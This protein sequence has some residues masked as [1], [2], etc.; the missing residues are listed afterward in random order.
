MPLSS[1]NCSDLALGGRV[2]L[3]E[4]A[5]EHDRVGVRTVG[6][7]RLRPVEQVLVAVAR[8]RSTPSTRTRRTRSSGSVIAH[9]PIL[10]IVRR[11]RAHRSFCAIVPF[12]IDR[13]RGEAD[14][15]AHRGDHARRALAELDDRQQREPAAAAPRASLA[16]AA[17]APLAA[18]R[19]L[20]R[21]RSA[22]C[23]SRRAA[24][25]SMPNVLYSLRSR[26]YGG[27]SPCSSSSR[28]GRISLSTNWRTASRTIFSSSDHS[29]IRRIVRDELA[30][31]PSG[32]GPGTARATARR[33]W[34]S[35]GSPAR[36]MH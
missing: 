19:P 7:E 32:V 34:G 2:A 15:H 24:S 28:C 11:S 26:S 8:A 17:V 4:L 12:D 31:H 3:V 21:P 29:N 22:R 5:D 1:T 10:S 35:V 18:P 14:R 23:R 36:P 9:A 30:G 13:G 16:R 33:L 25:W 20:P 6:D 27:R